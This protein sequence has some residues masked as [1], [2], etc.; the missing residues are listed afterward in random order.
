MKILLNL[1]LLFLCSSV[2]SAQTIVIDPGHGGRSYVGSQDERNL[3]SPNNA[4]SPS[5]IKEK[6]LTLELSLI[7]EERLKALAKTRKQEVEVVL[8]RR[9]DINLNF[10]KRA[11]ICAEAS[12]AVIVSIHFNAS[13]SGRGLGSLCVIQ[14]QEANVNFERDRV[15]ANG[16]AEACSRAVRRY[17]PDSRSRGSIE[18]GYL[19]GGIGSNFFFQLSRYRRLRE[20]PKCFLEVEFM[21]RDDVQEKLIDRRKESFPEIATEIAGFLLDW[22]VQDHHL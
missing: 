6:N 16:L 9:E 10:T 5:G 22:L 11:A 18:D 3:S 15:F 2:A 4:T 20:V 19:H 7:L 13:R 21:D 8:T 17:V 14:N 1:L 12:P